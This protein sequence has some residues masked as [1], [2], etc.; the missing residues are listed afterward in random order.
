MG[1][2]ILEKQM[3][4]SEIKNLAKEWYTLMIKGT[5][6]IKRKKVA[7]GGDYHMESAELLVKDGSNHSDVW[8]FNIWFDKEKQ[9]EFDSLVNIKPALGN[10]S[11]GLEN[12]DVIK[13]ATK[14]ISSWI[15]FD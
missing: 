1:M 13:E 12:E 14:I 4:L 3:L 11:R 15:K 5:V 9:L 8:G 10:K 2:K 7:I 6:D